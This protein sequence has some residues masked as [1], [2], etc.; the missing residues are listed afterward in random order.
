MTTNC[1]LRKGLAEAMAAEMLGPLDLPQA[2]EAHVAK[3]MV[4]KLLEAED[5]FDV[6]VAALV[7][8][9][10]LEVLSGLGGNGSVFSSAMLDAVFGGYCDEATESEMASYERELEG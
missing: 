6:A 2:I 1:E 3:M 10:Q 4:S 5:D 9:D 8:R 7:A